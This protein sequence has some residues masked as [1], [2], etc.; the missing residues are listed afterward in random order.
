MP[1][2]RP[3]PPQPASSPPK[4]S[5]ALSP[6]PSTNPPTP[7]RERSKKLAIAAASLPPPPSAIS[8][9]LAPP[10]PSA[11]TPQRAL[12]PTLSEIS[13][14]ASEDGADRHNL[15]RR[16]GSASPG[17]DDDDDEAG[18]SAP[19][20]RSTAVEKAEDAEVRC[21]W[22]DCGETFSSLQPFIEHLHQF[23]IGIHKS[24]YS[25]EWT[26]CSRKGKSQTSRFALLSHLRSHTGEKPFTCP[27]PECDKS[28][29][30]SDALSKHMRVQH[31][32]QTPGSRKAAA[33]AAAAESTEVA[34]ASEANGHDGEASTAAGAGLGAADS[35]GDELLELAEGEEDDAFSFA[36]RGAVDPAVA[37]TAEE[38]GIQDKLEPVEG[39]EQ[40]EDDAILLKARRG[41]AREARDRERERKIRETLREKE[42]ARSQRN[43]D[44]GVREADVDVEIDALV[45]GSSSSSRRPG[46]TDAYDSDS[47]SEGEGNRGKKRGG[48]GDLDGTPGSRSSKKSR[49][50]LKNGDAPPSPT[51]SRGGLAAEGEREKGKEK[52]ELA[53]KNARTR[54]VV[55]K[56]RLRYIRQENEKLWQGLKRHQD[57]E[58]RLVLECRNALERALVAELGPDVEAIFSPPPSPRHPQVDVE[59][60]KAA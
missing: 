32:I 27:R 40:K 29:T 15:T 46:R 54:Y 55:E 38:L 18:P 47:S 30:R 25:C 60:S 19:G 11:P 23:H 16:D 22:N 26:G 53:R 37:L 50:S 17:L 49:P 45:G 10:T 36:Q 41:W 4:S 58:H 14:S 28:F 42:M 43:G 33:Q 6:S 39:P 56:A 7:S 44:D 9:S 24:K 12:S 59:P 20:N 48:G 13:T 51:A 8:P 34:D 35:L 2:R 21:M 52:D 1:R 31:N 57:E 3:Q 5:K